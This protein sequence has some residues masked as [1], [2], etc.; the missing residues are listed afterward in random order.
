MA[1]SKAAKDTEKVLSVA[2]GATGAGDDTDVSSATLASGDENWRP[3]TRMYMIFVT[4]MI[5]TLMVA[6][7]ATSLSVALPV[8]RQGLSH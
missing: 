3:T 6:L 8:G 5:I 4:M 2:D 7:D 1:D